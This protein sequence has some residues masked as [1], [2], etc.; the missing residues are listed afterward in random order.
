LRSGEDVMGAVKYLALAAAAC[1][2]LQVQAAQAVVKVNFIEP[3]HYMDASLY[4]RYGA[5]SRD[6][7]LREIERAVQRAGER[8][9][10][11]DE[12]LTIDVLDVDLAGQFEPWHGV[13]ND[14]RY[15]RD[16]TWPSI[17][18]RYVL[19]RPSQPPL[20][21]EERVSDPS[22]LQFPALDRTGEPM[23]YEKAML[24]RWFR[25]RFG[26]QGR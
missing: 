11:P 23:P 24:Q 7:A 8:Y 9:L 21:A 17:K 5:R 3:E 2:V 19:E 1:S 15:M 14:I 20:Q 22:Y 25:T 16:I 12:T 4:G 26:S 13:P 6:V 10:K 18:L